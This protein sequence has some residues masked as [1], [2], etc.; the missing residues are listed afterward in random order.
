MRED[1][2]GVSPEVAQRGS[3]SSHLLPFFGEEGKKYFSSEVLRLSETSKFKEK[4]AMVSPDDSSRKQ[5]E[6]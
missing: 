5:S 6:L 3:Q 1:I 4:A 2:H